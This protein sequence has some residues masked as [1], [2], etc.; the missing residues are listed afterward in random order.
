M[1]LE[2]TQDATAVGSYPD[3]VHRGVASVSGRRCDRTLSKCARPGGR[4]GSSR[5]PHQS[6]VDDCWP[7]ADVDRL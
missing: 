1:R 6:E 7:T 3:A 4:T 5:S 2:V